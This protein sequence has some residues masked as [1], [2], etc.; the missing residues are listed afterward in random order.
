MVTNQLFASFIY[1]T[2]LCCFYDNDVP[3]SMRGDQQDFDG[4]FEVSNIQ[5]GFLTVRFFGRLVDLTLKVIVNLVFGE[6]VC[7]TCSSDKVFIQE[8]LFSI[9]PPLNLIVSKT[10]IISSNFYN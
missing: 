3:P 7:M 5:R 2:F 9:P 6:C 8:H 4:L 10:F 1:K